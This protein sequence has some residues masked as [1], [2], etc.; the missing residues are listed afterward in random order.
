MR[1]FPTH[2]K[3][4]LFP[5]TQ[6]G[7]A[8]PLLLLRFHPLKWVF[9]TEPSKAFL[10]ENA[11]SRQRIRGI[12]LRLAR[13][14]A[15]HASTVCHKVKRNVYRS[16]AEV[17]V[18]SSVRNSLKISVMKFFAQN[19][20]TRRQRRRQILYLHPKSPQRWLSIIQDLPQLR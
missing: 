2:M 4:G 20:T 11:R 12:R 1:Y 15:R 19:S 16:Y 7:Y 10:S 9:P 13:P 8:S 5:N 17:P 14:P 6:E 18:K 3:V